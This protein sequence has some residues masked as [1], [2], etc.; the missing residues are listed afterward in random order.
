[1]SNTPEQNV[2]RQAGRGG[3][4]VLGAKAFFILS[5]LVQQALLPRAIGL[6]GYGALARVMAMGNILNNVVVASSTQGVSRAVARSIGAEGGAFRATL[7]VHLPLAAVVALLFAALAPSFAR[8]EGAPYIV[9]PLYFMAAVS[10]FYGLYA[11]FIGL[12][13]GRGQFTLQA[14]LDVTFAVLRTAGLVGL[15]WLFARSGSA[16]ALGSTVGFACAAAAIVPTAAIVSRRWR[17]ATPASGGAST[18]GPAA[19][20][21]AAYLLELAPLALAQ[22]FTNSV[23]QADITL[24]GHFLSQGGDAR[25]ADEWVAVYRACQLFAFLPYQL[26]VSVNQILF[27]MVAR[28]RAQGDAQG[29]KL[30]TER[31]ARLAAI[32]CGMLVSVIVALPSQLLAFAYSRDVAERGGEVLRILTLGQGAFAM[33]A[34]ATT[35]LAGLGKE[36]L[37]AAITFG[38]LVTMIALAGLLTGGAGFGAAQLRATAIGVSI[39]LLLALV[40][41]AGAVRRAA[42]GFVTFS[43]SARV[44]LA[45]GATAA[46]GSFLPTGH[47]RA[48][49]IVLAACVA[50]AY[51]ATLVVVRELSSRDT[52]ALAT[53]RGKRGPAEG[54]A[55][56]G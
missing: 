56:S 39:A 3:I 35:V 33:L 14:G 21:P 53:L 2:A 37:A 18:A 25:S 55:D 16:G 36:R 17:A 27:P 8:F 30:Y 54:P 11:P 26:L 47:G 51:L 44:L 19:V 10:F 23:M 15:G 12:L 13:N 49:T 34:V 6:S 22:L 38:T 52:A 7:R 46:A 9:V 24:L 4:A 41:A 5:G 40:A 45:L 1:M 32:A 43:T 50:L 31:G 28:A 48:L 29:V 42:G 20:P